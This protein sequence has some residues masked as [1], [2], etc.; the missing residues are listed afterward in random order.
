M[1]YGNMERIFVPAY[2]TTRSFMNIKMKIYKEN[3]TE[4]ECDMAT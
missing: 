2:Y 3:V 4:V 1:Q